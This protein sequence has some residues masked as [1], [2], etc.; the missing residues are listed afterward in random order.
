MSMILTF[1][2]FFKN[3]AFNRKSETVKFLGYK[4]TYFH[5]SIGPGKHISRIPR[6]HSEA[7]E[8]PYFQASSGAKSQKV[9]LALKN[10]I[11]KKL[12]EMHVGG[13]NGFLSTLQVSHIGLEPIY[14]W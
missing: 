3:E 7:H 5:D 8:N 13:Q 1:W 10:S 9:V 2:T 12:F 14:G 4:W 11:F 6:A